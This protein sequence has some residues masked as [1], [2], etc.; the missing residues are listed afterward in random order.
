MKVVRPFFCGEFDERIKPAKSF[1]GSHA[2]ARTFLE[3]PRGSSANA[4]TFFFRFAELPQT[5][6]HIPRDL[7]EYPQTPRQTPRDL[8]EYPQTPKHFPR[9][10]REY[11]QTPRQTPRDLR[12]YPQTPKHFPW[13]LRNFRGT[14]ALWPLTARDQRHSP[15]IRES[16]LSSNSRCLRDHPFPIGNSMQN[17]FEVPS[18][19]R[20]G[21]FRAYSLRLPVIF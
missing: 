6:K 8:R 15:E 21:I 20:N 16:I 18:P 1:Y 12:E 17:A 11:P 19:I 2:I 5:P 9:D 14:K 7:R 4:K 10:L 3:M 13:D